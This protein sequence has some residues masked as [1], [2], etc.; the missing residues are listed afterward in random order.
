MTIPQQNKSE[1]QI[2]CSYHNHYH[3]NPNIPIVILLIYSMSKFFL[4]NGSVLICIIVAI[5]SLIIPVK[6]IEESI[7]SHHEARAQLSNSNYQTMSGATLGNSSGANNNNI[8]GSQNVTGSIKLRNIIGNAI[9]S[10][11]KVSLIQAAMAAE[12]AVGNNSHAVAANL[13]QENGFL[14]YTVWVA[15]SNYIFHRIVVDAGNGKLLTVQNMLG[16][17]RSP[18]LSP[19]SGPLS[20]P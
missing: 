18:L 2:R 7:V 5:A 13:G 10:Q 15:D 17:G 4:K 20:I 16:L 9:S 19:P 6:P 3:V 14:V 1:F 8:V 11:I 12:K